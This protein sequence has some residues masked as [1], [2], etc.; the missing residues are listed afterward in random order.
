MRVMA[1]DTIGAG[2]SSIRIAKLKD[3]RAISEIYAPY[4][5]ETVISF[6]LDPPGATEMAGR[7]KRI[8]ASLPSAPNLHPAR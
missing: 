4:V 3:A 1:S 2:N 7:M 8:G 6:E 5:A